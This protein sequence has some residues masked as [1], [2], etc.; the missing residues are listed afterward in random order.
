MCHLPDLREIAEQL[1]QENNQPPLPA[2][3]FVFLMHQGYQ[4]LYFVADGKND[5]PPVY[6]YLE[7]EQGIVKKF[8]HF[9]EMVLCASTP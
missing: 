3:A 9:S 7:G 6:G 1:L 4:F 2:Q 5:D 8:E